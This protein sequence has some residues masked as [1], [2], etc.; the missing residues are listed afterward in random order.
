MRRP[1]MI[2]RQLLLIEFGLYWGFLNASLTMVE[3][4]RDEGIS[5][6]GRNLVSIKNLEMTEG[7]NEQ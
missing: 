5:K 1:P 4:K 3:L 7:F 6:V 2:Y